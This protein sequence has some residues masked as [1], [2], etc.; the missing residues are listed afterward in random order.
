MQG[1]LF[2]SRSA[3]RNGYVTDNTCKRR[4]KRHREV[5][6]NTARKIIRKLSAPSGGGK[7]GADS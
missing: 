4:T 6:E 3:K 1:T 7:G 5:N 2:V